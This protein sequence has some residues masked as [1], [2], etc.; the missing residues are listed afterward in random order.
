MHL[1][2]NFALVLMVLLMLVGLWGCGPIMSTS[3]ISEA[4]DAL[5]KAESVNAEELAPYEYTSAQE[6]IKK[7]DELW[8]YSKFGDS[9]DFAKRAIDFAKAAEKKALEDPWKSPIVAAEEKAAEEAEL[10]AKK[11]AE[12]EAE[13]K[14]KEKDIDED[15]QET[16]EEEVEGFVFG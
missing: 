13:R 9:V 1:R 3:K 15:T 8:G 16:E 14:A 2:K 6:F 7:A 4:K 5:A 12:K 10:K 11:E